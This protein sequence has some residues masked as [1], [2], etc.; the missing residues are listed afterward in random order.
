MMRI[1]MIAGIAG[2]LVG[3]LAGFLW[4]GTAVRRMQADLQSLKDQQMAAE[5]AQEQLKG[6]RA[7]LKRTQDE[8]ASERERRARLEVIVSEGRK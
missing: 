2:V 7:Q 3:V 1:I 4:W 6:V 5:V 8:L